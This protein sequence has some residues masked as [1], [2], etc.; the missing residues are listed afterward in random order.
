[1]E[2]QEKDISDQ[3]TVKKIKIEHLPE[4]KVVGDNI[5]IL[6]IICVVGGILLNGGVLIGLFMKVE[7]SKALL[8]SQLLMAI[9]SGSFGTLIGVAIGGVFSK[10]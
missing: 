5:F 10:K 3:E 2:L 7:D 4:K 8:E 1:M 6:V 9:V